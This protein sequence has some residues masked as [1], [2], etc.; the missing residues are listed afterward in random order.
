MTTT[1]ICGSCESKLEWTDKGDG[2]IIIIYNCAY[3]AEN[4]L[5]LAKL[6]RDKVDN[7]IEGHRINAIGSDK[8]QIN[9]EEKIA[10]YNMDVMGMIFDK[11]GVKV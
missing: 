5:R 8:G 1:Y 3:C 4:E 2:G 11:L 6:C 10:K 9:L 7:L